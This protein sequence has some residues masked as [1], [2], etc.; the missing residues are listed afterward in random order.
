MLR[1]ALI[2]F[3]LLVLPLL[4]T[5]IWAQ[6]ISAHLVSAKPGM[7]NYVAGNPRLYSPTS[8]RAKPLVVR[9][10]MVPGNMLEAG[11]ED[12]VELLLN[13]G[14]YL[15]ISGRAQLFVEGTSF[16]EMHYTLYEGNAIL[17]AVVLDKKIHSLRISTPCGQLRVLEPGLYR[18]VVGK[19]KE[20]AVSVRSGKL[21]WTKGEAESSILKKGKKYILPPDENNPLQ[22]TELNK[23]I[24]DSF[25]L[26]SQHR[27][28]YLAD[29]LAKSTAERRMAVYSWYP[30]SMGGGW[31]FD[32]VIG[33]YTFMPFSLF[34]TSPYGN[35][36]YNHSAPSYDP[37][38][39]QQ[40][41]LPAQPGMTGGSGAGA[42]YP[43]PTN[44][45]APQP[46]PAISPHAGMGGAPQPG[47][48][49]RPATNPH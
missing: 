11:P 44:Q 3:L 46:H 15:R 34:N 42:A 43:P 9:E 5:A 18:I 48:S 17:E 20:V 16:A 25:D 49:G 24:K 36:Y 32:P 4:G 1:G 21:A 8:L 27:D 41:T 7:V 45:P 6:D 2:G 30:S 38:Y 14:S 23:K 31:L 29:A 47:G 35:R 40:G 33:G 19:P 28:Q 22:S 13:P 26:W 39:P 37:V 12:R 10:Q